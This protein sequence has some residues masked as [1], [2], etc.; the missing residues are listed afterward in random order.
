MF[1]TASA[2]A[3]A[4]RPELQHQQ[5]VS[6]ME[7]QVPGSCK[8]EESIGFECDELNHFQ[9]THSVQIYLLLRQVSTG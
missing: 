6:C 9:P 1:W 4:H 7:P 3:G 5:L 8:S 2:Q